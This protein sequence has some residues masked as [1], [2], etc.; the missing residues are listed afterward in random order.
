MDYTKTTVAF[1]L[2]FFWMTLVHLYY[3][4]TKLD[5]N[6]T[7]LDVTY[8]TIAQQVNYTKIIGFKF[9]YI[10]VTPELHLGYV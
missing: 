7:Y 8:I 10:L 4:E 5:N 3:I 9:S 6:W 2:A 1:L